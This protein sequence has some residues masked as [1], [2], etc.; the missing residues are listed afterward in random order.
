MLAETVSPSLSG[1]G[2]LTTAALIL[3]GVALV[4]S[5]IVIWILT[6]QLMKIVKRVD[7]TARL[8]TIDQAYERGGPKRAAVLTQAA[9]TPGVLTEP[10]PKPAPPAP[11]PPK[12]GLKITQGTI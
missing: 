3:V 2:E 10:P 1:V 6:A 7:S 12:S 8:L 11:E 4:H 5:V 9:K